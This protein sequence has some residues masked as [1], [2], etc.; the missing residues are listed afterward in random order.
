[1]K[2]AY[3]A[4]EMEVTQVDV[5]QILAASVS[6]DWLIEYGGV[7]EDGLEDPE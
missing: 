6:S 3:T 4:P 1:M 7:D 2:K 5:S